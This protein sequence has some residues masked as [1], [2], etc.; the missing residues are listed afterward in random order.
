MISCELLKYLLEEFECVL[1]DD[2]SS[3]LCSKEGDISVPGYYKVESDTSKFLLTNDLRDTVEFF[4]S[5]GT[6]GGK[7]VIE[8][9]FG[10]EPKRN[11]MFPK[12]LE[13]LCVDIKDVLGKLEEFSLES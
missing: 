5:K 4:Y 9:F 3:V 2:T 13:F 12:T 1:Y 8:I 11:C 10:N 7:E 6:L